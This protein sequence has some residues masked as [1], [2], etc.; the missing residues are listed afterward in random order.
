M[1]EDSG[2]RLTLVA[3]VSWPTGANDAGC[4]GLTSVTPLG[5]VR[6]WIT[7]TAAKLGSALGP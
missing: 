6:G 3:V 7:D 5:L 1:F 2:G 4:G